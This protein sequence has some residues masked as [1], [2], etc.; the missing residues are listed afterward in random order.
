M[1]R[2]EGPSPG[3]W[4]GTWPSAT[5]WTRGL[6]LSDKGTRLPRDTQPLNAR[7]T[8]E[9]RVPCFQ[10]A[11]GLLGPSLCLQGGDS[12]AVAARPASQSVWSMHSLITAAS[13]RPPQCSRKRP[14]RGAQMFKSSRNRRL[15]RRQDVA[16]RPPA[17][18]SEGLEPASATCCWDKSLNFLNFCLLI[19]NRTNRVCYYNTSEDSSRK[20]LS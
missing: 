6:R 11:A 10:A 3:P 4:E 9:S 19:C 20:M 2:Q 12:L 8:S 17:L 13:S 15:Q 7:H 14:Q 16:L 1:T 18:E 5:I